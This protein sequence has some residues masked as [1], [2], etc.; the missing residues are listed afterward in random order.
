M[1]QDHTRSNANS[2][3]AYLLIKTMILDKLKMLIFNFNL[4][5]LSMVFAMELFIS[6]EMFSMYQKDQSVNLL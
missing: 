3:L 2:S 1:L 6:G 4:I 5:L